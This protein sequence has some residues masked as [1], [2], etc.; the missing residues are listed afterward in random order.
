VRGDLLV[1][2]RQKIVAVVDDDPGML[3]A[4]GR[5]LAA[6]GFR[7]EASPSAEAFLAS[8]ASEYAD[9]LLLDIQLGQ[10]SGLELRRQLATSGCTIP[11]IFITAVEDE[12][13]RR[14]ALKAGCA[15][16]LRKPFP[17]HLLFAA[18]EKALG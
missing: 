3:K 1:P 8:G 6:H 14:E 15:G 17:S 4:I 10:M 9:C 12:N 2:I 11:V 5:L 18:I 13:T 16:Y 7:V